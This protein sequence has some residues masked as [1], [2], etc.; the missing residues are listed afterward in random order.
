VSSVASKWKALG[1]MLLDPDLVDNGHLEIIEKNNPRDVTECCKQMFMKWRD[2]NKDA[3]WKQLI[4]ALQS[5]G[6]ELNYLAE[7]VKGMLQKCESDKNI[8]SYIN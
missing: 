7:Q 6:V 2:T 3:S 5:S 4:T 1:E 8:A